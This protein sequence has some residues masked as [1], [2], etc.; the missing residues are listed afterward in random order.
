MRVPRH[1][2]GRKLWGVNGCGLPREEFLTGN[3]RMCVLG[4][5]RVHTCARVGAHACSLQAKQQPQTSWRGSEGLHRQFYTRLRGLWLSARAHQGLCLFGGD[6]DQFRPVTACPR[7]FSSHSRVARLVTSLSGPSEVMSYIPAWPP[8]QPRRCLSQ[9]PPFP[10]PTLVPFP[11][12]AR[13]GRD[14]LCPSQTCR[15]GLRGEEGR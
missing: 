14:A 9:R 11:S 12:P 4:N 7:R 15:R 5:T 2:E 13:G 8:A 1:L 6:A 10:S 3:V